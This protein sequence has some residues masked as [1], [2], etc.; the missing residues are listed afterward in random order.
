M[1][2]KKCPDCGTDLTIKTHTLLVDYVD[3]V[4][5]DFPT[6]GECGH[7]VYNTNY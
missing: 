3:E 7:V 5:L 6:C 4:E 1:E 2:D